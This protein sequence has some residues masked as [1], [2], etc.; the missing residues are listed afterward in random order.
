VGK[1]NL[2]DEV[3]K[4]VKAVTVMSYRDTATGPNSMVAISQ[5]WLGR[6]ATAGKRV[7]LGAETDPLPECAYC[8]FAKDG[9]QKM[10]QELA[11]VDAA[12]RTAGAFGGIAIHRYGAWRT[13][14]S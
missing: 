3:L 4:R 5:D 12:E 6:G 1:K 8:T 14:K 13:L 9:T 7:R 10:T 2:A 11:K